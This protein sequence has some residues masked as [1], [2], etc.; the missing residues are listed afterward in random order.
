MEIT[1]VTSYFTPEIGAASNRLKNMSEALS[2]RFDFVH[3]LCPLPNYP[4]GK[5][6]KNYRGKF[7]IKESIGNINVHRYW[8]YSS[9]S[10]NIFKRI[11]SMFSFAFSLWFYAINFNQIKKS[12]WVIIQNSPLLISFSSIILFKFI[13][14]RKIA[15]NVSDLWPLSALELGVIKKGKFYDLLEW[16]E[17]FNYNNSDLI[18]G[19]SN[20]I[21]QHVT[22]KVQKQILLYR[23]LPKYKTKKSLNKKDFSDFKIVYAGLL[24]VAQG[25]FDIIQKINFNKLDVVFHIYGEGYELSR[26]LNFIENNPNSNIKYN[27]SLSKEDLLKVL[28]TY[29]AS[30]VPLTTYIKGAVPSK[31]FELVD[32]SIPVLLLGEGEA[33]KLIEDWGVGYVCKPQNFN[34]LEKNIKKIKKSNIEYN[35]LCQNC[36]IASNRELDFDTQIENLIK[37][38]K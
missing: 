38:I 1:I 19:Q 9:I 34:M 18:L 36:E 3:V 24:G 31:I 20:E 30:I 35:I 25:I 22:A 14:R 21:L 7:Q 27:G 6:F 2:D 12:K 10:S 16:F 26:I 23:N 32:L 8:I 5:I 29:H 13:F 28:P 11:L 15:L 33:S 37:I 17:K 4:K